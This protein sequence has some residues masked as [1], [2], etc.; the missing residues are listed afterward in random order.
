MRAQEDEKKMKLVI[1]QV[2]EGH[3]AKKNVDGVD[4]ISGRGGRPRLAASAAVRLCHGSIVGG[5]VRRA[6]PFHVPRPYIAT[7]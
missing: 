3:N 4:R 7:R 2:F 1:A 5:G 6:P